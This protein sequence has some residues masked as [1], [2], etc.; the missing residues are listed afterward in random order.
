[1]Y[2]R[3]IVPRWCTAAHDRALKWV[4]RKKEPENRH[5]HTYIKIEGA[6][7]KSKIAS[8]LSV[9]ELAQHVLLIL[10]SEAPSQVYCRSTAVLVPL[11]FVNTERMKLSTGRLVV[12]HAVKTSA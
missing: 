1:M 2:P 11:V 5:A 3:S 8:V 7:T 10:N 9:R 6:K 12:L 4:I